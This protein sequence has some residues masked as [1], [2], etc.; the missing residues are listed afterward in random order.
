M[1][2]DRMAARAA[3][4]E[5][6]RKANRFQILLIVLGLGVTM[7]VAGLV[8]AWDGDAGN[9]LT[10]RLLMAGGAVTAIVGGTLAWRFRLT[11][12]DRAALKPGPTR[13]DEEQWQRRASLFM[14]PLQALLALS[15]GVPAVGRIVTG[16]GWPF[17]DGLMA[18]IVLLWPWLSVA[19]IQGW[20]GGSRKV[21]K[22]LED[23]WTEVVRAS[24][25]R[26]GYVALLAGV[27]VAYGVSLWRPHWTPFA[28]VGVLT[29]GA[30]VPALRFA[31]L[32][33]SADDA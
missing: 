16:E 26:W 14:I 24:A 21:R 7:A 33:R 29:V 4:L 28:L 10:G 17:V 5:A 19:L 8:L 32:D 3:R 25:M 31:L 11:D 18:L 12:D 23:E 9:L 15:L 13:R 30:V 20:D 2:S 1:D 27:G 22:F 6:E